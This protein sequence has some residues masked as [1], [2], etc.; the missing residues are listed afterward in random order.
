[1]SWWRS[2]NA[3]AASLAARPPAH[4][5]ADLSGSSEEAEVSVT[6]APMDGEQQLA[7]GPGAVARQPLGSDD[8]DMA[9]DAVMLEFDA[10]EQLVSLSQLSL[11]DTPPQGAAAEA[12]PEAAQPPAGTPAGQQQEQQAAEAGGGSPGGGGEQPGEAGTE[13]QPA[14]AAASEGKGEQADA[15]HA[16]S[17]PAAAAVASN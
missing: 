16:S 5:P 1:M 7:G 8:A 6:P 15:L 10:A 12:A 14:A 3:R 2:A 17:P 13:E 11:E 4:P 9:D